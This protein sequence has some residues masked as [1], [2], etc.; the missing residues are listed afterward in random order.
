MKRLSAPIVASVALCLGSTCLLRAQERLWPEPVTD[1]ELAEVPHGD[2]L[3]FRGHLASWGYTALDQID[4]SN[5][6][7]LQVAW[8]VTMNRGPNE[9]SPLVRDG[10]MYL[11]HS[12]DVIQALDA[13]SGDLIWEY[14]RQWPE[15]IMAKRSMSNLAAPINRGMAIY[16]DGLFFLTGDTYLIRLDAH[17]GL[18]EWETRIGQYGQVSHTSPPI[19]ANGKIISG[20]TCDTSLPGGCF[21]TAHDPDDGRELWRFHVIPRPGEP[22]S[23]TWGDLEFEGRIQVGAWF[24]GSYDPELDT[25]YW[26]TSVPAPSAEVQRGTGKGVMLYSNS[27]VA[28]DPNTGK[29]RWYFQHLPRDNWDMDHPFERMLVDVEVQPDAEA[30]WVQ[31][32]GIEPGARRKLLTGVP[33]KNGMVWTLDRETGEFLWARPTVYQNLIDSIDATTGAVKINEE[34]VPKGFGDKLDLVC[35]AASGG[36]NWPTGSYSPRTETMY[37]PLQNLCMSM[38]LTVEDPGPQDFYAF[39][40]WS[41]MSPGKDNVGRL[42]AVSAR[43]GKTAWQQEHAAG[44]MATLATGGDLVFMGDTNRRLR[45]FDAETGEHLWAGI[46]NGPVTG[47][48]VSYEVNGE[49]YIAVGVGGGDLLSGSFNRYSGNRVRSGSNV[50]V[51]F[52]LP[53]RWRDTSATASSDVPRPELPRAPAASAMARAAGDLPLKLHRSAPCA[54]FDA[55]QVER[56]QQRYAQQ[57]TTCHGATLRGGNHGT[58]LM[59][60]AF[61]RRWGDRPASGLA[62]TIRETMPPGGERTLTEDATTDL[63]AFILSQSGD[64]RG[65]GNSQP[66]LDAARMCFTGAR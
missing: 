31:N 65:T 22:G 28:L 30:T 8:S 18:L 15:D 50:M 5:V 12:G 44:S 40:S 62:K 60:P 13:T 6:D 3:S 58:A 25:V 2:W 36:R 48:P 27:T 49:Q 24:V 56:G 41:Q 19:I 63:V 33:G 16:G 54:S 14:R 66:A 21:I 23:E 55:A 1:A 20:R 51:A 35:P 45:A 7:Q 43:T 53:A 34:V 10:V 64:V 26:G 52:K 9:P 38:E 47:F 11:G 4:R 29:L 59:G 46:V 42:E 32:P 39:S 57:C 61:V 17:T 37:I